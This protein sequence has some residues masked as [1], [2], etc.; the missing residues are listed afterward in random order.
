[1]PE[2]LPGP[3][4]PRPQFVRR[5]WLNLNGDWEFAFDDADEGL[6]A[7]WKEGR[8]LPQRIVVPFAYQTELSGINDQSVHEIVWYAR[9][10]DVPCVVARAGHSAAFRRSRLSLHGMDKRTGSGTQPGWD[11]YRSG[12]TSRHICARAATASRYA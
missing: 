2:T 9:D 5:D 6:G 1:M 12:S 8:T 7:G 3:E 11:T 10:F 4:Y